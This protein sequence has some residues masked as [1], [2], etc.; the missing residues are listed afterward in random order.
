MIRRAVSAF[1]LLPLVAACG[2]NS[3][4][5]PDDLLD[6][7]KNQGSTAGY[8]SGPYGTGVGDVVQDLCWDAW[9]D[10]KA[11][12]YDPSKFQ[13]LC[14]SDFHADQDARLLLVE[15]SAVWCVA[16]RFEYGGSSGP[17]GRPSLADHLAER[18]DQG[19]RVLGTIFQDAASA[20]ATGDD[21]SLWARTYALEFPFALDSDHHLGLFTSSSIAPFNLLIDTRTMKSVLELEGDEP[22]VL[23][24]KVDDFLKDAS[25]E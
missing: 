16:C 10:P 13:R 15:S 22:A 5:V 11:D 18:R 19:F 6:A 25:A 4:G 3:A 20:P 23:Y 12:G 9:K 24:G 2:S 8:P 17:D 14:L 1:G 7:I 21:A